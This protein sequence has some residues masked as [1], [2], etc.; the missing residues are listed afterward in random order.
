MANDQGQSDIIDLARRTQ[1]LFEFNRTVA[2]QLESI[3][4]VQEGIAEELEGFVKNWFKRRHEATETAFKTL[5]EANVAGK[6]DPA[7]A[8]QAITEWQRGSFERMNADLN[9]WAALCMRCADAA[10]TVPSNMA[11]GDANL[12]GAGKTTSKTEPG[13]AG[14]PRSKADGKDRS[15]TKSTD[16]STPV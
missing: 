3:V 12:N 8:M 16:H 15:S 11:S 7:A 13:A 1:A 2:P 6:T 4:Q 5:Q 9:D 14:K 10:I